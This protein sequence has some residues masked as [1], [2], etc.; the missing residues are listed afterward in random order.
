MN[1]DEFDKILHRRIAQI[2]VGAS[3]IRNQ[4]GSGLIEICRDYFEN[5]IDLNELF[6]ALPEKSEFI[7][8][9]DNHTDEI[10]RLFPNNAKS[11]GAARKGLNLFFREICYNK[12]FADKFQ[13]PF[14]F[15]ANNE[16]LNHLEVP[17]DND[18]ATGLIQ[19]FP[20]ELP[21]WNRIKNLTK[22]ESNKYQNKAEKLAKQKGI[23]KVHLDLL[24]WREKK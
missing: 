16:K 2:A 13:L 7:L 19:Q 21:K 17:L 23:A 14:E 1:K 9:L 6:K 3:A 8:F 24:F 10:V 12:Y 4:G 20:N 5:K 22:D 11:W 15:S 18:V